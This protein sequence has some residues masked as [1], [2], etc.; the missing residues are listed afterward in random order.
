MN[1]R[2]PTIDKTR[3]DKT[4]FYLESY[5]DL[6]K[7]E[8]VIWEMRGGGGEGG[9]HS[10]LPFYFRDRAFSISRTRLSRS[11]EQAKGAASEESS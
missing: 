1:A 3:Q 10:F 11:L 5:T 8:C 6:Y 4:M 2:H 9:L 7:Y